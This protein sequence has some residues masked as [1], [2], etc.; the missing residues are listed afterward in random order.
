MKFWFGQ[1]RQS[2][3]S[4]PLSFAYRLT[5]RCLG[6]PDLGRFDDLGLLPA[7]A[8]GRAPGALGPVPGPALC[9]VPG[10]FGEHLGLP[11]GFF[12]TAAGLSGAPSDDESRIASNKPANS[13]SV[14][15]RHWPTASPFKL[16]FMMP[17]SYTHL[18]L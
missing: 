16:T 12:F 10:G 2:S 6:F 11:M 9:P 8:A 17:V 5:L 3:R 7:S 14:R 1:R 4:S 13:F 18:T 15:S